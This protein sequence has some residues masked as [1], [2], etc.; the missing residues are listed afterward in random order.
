MKLSQSFTKP[1]RQAPNDADSANAAFLIQGGYLDQ[2]A[3]GIY[4]FLPLGWRVYRK[5][6]QIIREEMDAIGG[7][8]LSMPALHPAAPWK[9]S[10]RWDDKDVQEVMYQFE[11]H[12]GKPYGLGWTHE[13]IIAAIGKQH[14]QSYKDLPSAVYQIQA[15]FRNEPRA[16]SGLLR[17]REFIMKDL[18][19]FHRDE[20]DLDTFYDGMIEAYLK[21]YQRLGLDAWVVEAS[22]GAFTEYSHEFQVFSDAGEDTVYY[23]DDRKFAQ[24]EE[25]F[26]GKVG[27][28][29]GSQTVKAGK[30]IEVGNIFKLGTRFP[31]AAKVTY[32]DKDGKRQTPIM[33]SYGIGP[34]RA[35]GTIVE[36]SHDDKG[37]MWPE[38]VAP[39]QV[40]LLDI[41]KDNAIKKAAEKLYDELGKAGVEVLY[42]DRDDSAG[43]KFN[44]ADL[45]GIPKRVTV[46]SKTLEKDS[47]ELKQRDSD[48]TELI[49]LKDA[50]NKLSETR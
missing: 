35:M 25:I 50:V 40:H 30:A 9:A 11:D 24:N 28:K 16:K 43:V 6:E 31:E 8:E 32:L 41:G 3:A 17:G 27:D 12:S 13:E 14:I 36:T 42:D 33:A 4:S 39:Y 29:K 1:L 21:I 18:Y 44:D 45:L 49:P 48:K 5:V 15:K 26:E 20:K 47:V 23:T 22:G 7:Q 46:S 38:A 34:S 37:I 19:S 10:G 2:L